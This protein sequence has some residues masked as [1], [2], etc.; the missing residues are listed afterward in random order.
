MLGPPCLPK[1]Q[2]LTSR[3][4]SGARHINHTLWLI[5]RIS[6]VRSITRIRPGLPSRHRS[7]SVIKFSG[8]DKNRATSRPPPLISLPKSARLGPPSLVQ[9][10]AFEA[11]QSSVTELEIWNLYSGKVSS[12]TE[13]EF[14]GMQPPDSSENWS[15]VS[16]RR[17]RHRRASSL[18]CEKIAETSDSTVNPLPWTPVDV[19]EDE[20]RVSSILQ[21]LNSSFTRLESSAF[22][23][24]FLSQLREQIGKK[25]IEIAPEKIRIVLYGVGS[26][27][28]QESPRL[29]FSL[30]LLLRRELGDLVEEIEV[31]DPI[32][33]AVECAALQAKGCNVPR[34]NDRGLRRVDSPTLFFMPHC[35]ISLYANLLAANQGIFPSIGKIVILGNSFKAYERMADEKLGGRRE[36]KRALVDAGYFVEEISVAD[37]GFDE[38]NETLLRAFSDTSWHFFRPDRREETEVF[39]RTRII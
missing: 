36:R 28:L 37:L 9:I 18:G 38:G 4:K 35:E 12:V 19:D 8:F 6:T 5:E 24:R 3:A 32:F 15:V 7:H 17:R 21:K 25:L 16:S 22:Y 1:I 31:F 13:L 34:V 23:L 20:A 27:E 30:A 14:V 11:P 39:F 26:I 10:P 29:Q 2:L 33:S